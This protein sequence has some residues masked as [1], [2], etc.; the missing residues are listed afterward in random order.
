M[1]L[2]HIVH[3]NCDLPRA[4]TVAWFCQLQMALR[5]CDI[6]NPGDFTEGIYMLGP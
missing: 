4:L 3:S 5:L 2:L 6:W 1:G